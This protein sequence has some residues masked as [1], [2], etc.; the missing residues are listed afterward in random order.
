MPDKTSYSTKEKVKEQDKVQEPGYYKVI[1]HNDN[2]TTMDFVVSVIREV[3]HKSVPEANRIM[4]D[5]H[6]K[7]RGIVGEYTYDIAAT[8]VTQVEHKASKAGFP[9]RCTMEKN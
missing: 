4:L 6:K 5:V 1:L 2:Y 3:F 8:K 7:G 9:L